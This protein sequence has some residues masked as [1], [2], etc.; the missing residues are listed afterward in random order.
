[1][2]LLIS[3]STVAAYN[4]RELA[5]LNAINYARERERERERD[6]GKSLDHEGM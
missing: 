1:M 2:W 4:E 3:G 5:G 6:G